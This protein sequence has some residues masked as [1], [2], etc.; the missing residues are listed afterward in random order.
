MLL[1]LQRHLR[2]V[3]TQS[4]PTR[5]RLCVHVTVM[6]CDCAADTDGVA[7]TLSVA[8]SCRHLGHGEGYRVVEVSRPGQSDLRY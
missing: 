7:V 1:L 8:F 5:R 2:P 4:T 6:T 3:Q